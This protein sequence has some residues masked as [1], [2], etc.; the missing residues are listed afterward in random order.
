[1]KVFLDEFFFSHLDESVPNHKQVPT[2]HSI[3]LPV[4]FLD[5]VLDMPAVVL[6]QVPGLMLQKTVEV[7]QLQSIICR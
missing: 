7:P 4:Q 6:R 5:T 1:M 3:M 2:V